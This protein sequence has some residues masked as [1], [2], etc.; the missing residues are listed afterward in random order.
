MKKKT[1]DIIKEKIWK[2]LSAL[3]HLVNSGHFVT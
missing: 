1:V 3:F 2:Q